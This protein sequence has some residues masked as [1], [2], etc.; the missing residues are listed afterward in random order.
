MGRLGRGFAGALIALLVVAL[1]GCTPIIR[2]HGYV[3]SEE[4]LAAI[5]VG[6]DTRDSV[7]ASIGRPSTS[8]V[9]NEGGFY[10]IRSTWRTVG[11]R[12]PEEI[13]RQLVAIS[14]DAN[15]TVENI[16]RFGL[17]DGRVITLSRRVTSSS[18]RNLSFI[19]QLLGNFG[20]VRLSDAPT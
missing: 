11:W 4:E 2:N 6:V 8:G 3:P 15:G 7:A 17:E 10:Y 20:R 5:I 16:E 18:V 9:V 12:A 13:E 19:R 1:A 14:F